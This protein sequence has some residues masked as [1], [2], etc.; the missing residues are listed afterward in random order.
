MNSMINYNS[1]RYLSGLRAEMARVNMSQK[2][3]AQI[4]GLSTAAANRRMLG[5]VSFRLDELNTVAAHLGVQ[6][7]QLVGDTTALAAD[8]PAPRDTKAGAA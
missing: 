2:D 5:S 4:L 6:I 8:S 3:L 1:Q 7:D